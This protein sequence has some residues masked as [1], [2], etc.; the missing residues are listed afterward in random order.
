MEIRLL[1][2]QDDVMAVSHVYEES[3]RVP[4]KD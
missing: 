1:R 2:K 3:W 4:I